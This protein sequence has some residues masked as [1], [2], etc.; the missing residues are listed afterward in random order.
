MGWP[1]KRELSG[2]LDMFYILIE[3][4][5]LQIGVEG[6]DRLNKKFKSYTEVL[7]ASIYECLTSISKQKRSRKQ[8]DQWPVT[9][10]ACGETCNYDGVKIQEEK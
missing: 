8:K 5:S 6:D 1:E 3:V 7:G 4:M 10:S 9:Y 2:M